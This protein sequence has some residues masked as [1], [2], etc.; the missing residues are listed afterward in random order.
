MAVFLMEMMFR[1]CR[2]VASLLHILRSRS[3]FTGSLH[4]RIGRKRQV[5]YSA[6]DA[7]DNTEHLPT[8]C[9]T[10]VIE[11]NLLF[12]AVRAGVHR[13]TAV[14]DLLVSEGGSQSRSFSFSYSYRR[15][16]SPT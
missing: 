2:T 15:V 1:L 12:A 6:C 16:A 4:V 8:Q 13:H 7:R 11:R 3:V 14:D 10:N 5:S 9:I